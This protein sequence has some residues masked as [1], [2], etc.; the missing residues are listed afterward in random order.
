MNS[1]TRSR[2]SYRSAVVGGSKPGGCFFE[3]TVPLEAAR[4]V[5]M[6]VREGVVLL[7]RVWGN[8]SRDR[9]GPRMANHGMEGFILQR[10]TRD[11]SGGVKRD[12]VVISKLE[13]MDK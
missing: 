5:V 12:F 1:C 6:G 7:C 10:V 2:S 8:E 4:I 3:L 11:Q 13:D 9:S